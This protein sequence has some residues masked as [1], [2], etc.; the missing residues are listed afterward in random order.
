MEEFNSIV[1]RSVSS[2]PLHDK[3]CILPKEI[4]PPLIRQICYTYWL[5]GMTRM[6]KENLNELDVRHHGNPGKCNSWLFSMYLDNDRKV[7]MCK[8]KTWTNSQFLMK[9]NPLI[10]TYSDTSKLWELIWVFE[11]PMSEKSV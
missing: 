3:F 2:I 11:L 6:K 8:T 9:Q 7:Y 4:N 5:E 1:T 10:S